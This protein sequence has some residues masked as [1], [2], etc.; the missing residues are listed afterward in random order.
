MVETMKHPSELKP[1]DQVSDGR[2]GVSCEVIGNP[3]NNGH[4]VSVK[5]AWADEGGGHAI[6]Q[7]DLALI[8]DQKVVPVR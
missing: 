8:G 6:R 3:I 5:V 7:W 2:G 1:G 4:M